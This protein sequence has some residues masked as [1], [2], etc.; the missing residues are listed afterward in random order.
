MSNERVVFEPTFQEQEM[1][2][3]EALNDGWRARPR[4][5]YRTA[6]PPYCLFHRNVISDGQEINAAVVKG[7]NIHIFGLSIG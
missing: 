5:T 1:A 3:L 6:L 7:M 4:C 2:S